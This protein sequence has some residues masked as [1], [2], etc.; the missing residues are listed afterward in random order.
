MACLVTNQIGDNN[1][2]EK[3]GDCQRALEGDG[4]L[5]KV[6]VGR[7]VQRLSRWRFPGRVVMMN[8]ATLDRTFEATSACTSLAYGAVAPSGLQPAWDQS[9]MLCEKMRST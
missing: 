1:R 5:K 9:A 8:H 7:R 4:V 6:R 3:E 2:V